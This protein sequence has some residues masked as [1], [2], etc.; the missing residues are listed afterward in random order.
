MR[1]RGERKMGNENILPLV[2]G[3]EEMACMAFSR[4]S[5][6]GDR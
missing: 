6:G 4:L 2:L 3:C 1:R 5:G